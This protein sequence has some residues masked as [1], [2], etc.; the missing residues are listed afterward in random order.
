MVIRAPAA[1]VTGG[2]VLF[3][4]RYAWEADDYAPLRMEAPLWLY[5]RDGDVEYWAADLELHPPRLRYRF[6]LETAAGTRWYG[7]DGLRDTPAP[8]GSFEFPYIAE[9]DLPDSPAWARGATFYH[10]F[11]DRFARGA[12]RDRR[13]AVDPWHARVGRGTFLGGDLDG[14]IER[15]D[16][17]SS[18]SVDALYLTPI[19]AAPSNHKYDTSDYFSVDPDFG[20][21]AALRRLVEAVHG[22]GMRLI[23]DGVFNHAGSQ[24]PPFADVQ[25]HGSRSRYARWFF[26]DPD[27]HGH[28]PR[29][30]YQTW[31]TDV[32]SLPK[33]RTSEPEVRELI[34]RIGRFWAQEFGIDG[35]RLDVASEVD[36]RL[37]RAF[38]TVV[39]EVQ[40]DA[41]LVAEIW[42]PAMPW[43][44]GDQFDSV[45]NYP[46]RAAILDF[47]GRRTLDARAFLDAID[48]TRAA[49]PEPIHDHLYNLIGSH[50]AERPLTACGGDRSASTVATALLFTLPGSVSIYYGDEV[51]MEGGHDPASRAGMIWETDRQDARL[52][53]SHRR[54][55]ALRR[56]HPA[57]RTGRYERLME[58]GAVA[59]FARGSGTDRVVV[60]ANAG[61]TSE[62]ISLR[63]LIH[64]SGVRPNILETFSYGEP[65]TTLGRSEVRLAPQSVALVARREGP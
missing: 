60:L 35:W 58:Q 22:R 27:G 7:W 6:G 55:G 29:L 40:P 25:R 2:R 11:P 34:C 63:D 10:I 51:G 42:H 41:F 28:G 36:H 62:T 56:R 3:N 64:W 14:I 23:L 50:D 38:R 17:I 53:E 57:L 37:W 26:L 45:M 52:L 4:D 9:A 8:T 49:Y 61:A 16:H 31:A 20:G 18:L 5:A 30:G 15:L 54:L 59:A 47:A 48:R 1:E 24:W 32:A 39:R 46:F 13:P 65:S 44:R 19:F 33:L 12:G 43:L 21:D